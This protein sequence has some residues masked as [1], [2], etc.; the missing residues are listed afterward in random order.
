LENGASIQCKTNENQTCLHLA[1]EKGHTDVVKILLENGANIKIK[2]KDK[3]TCL[4]L[5]TK[6]GHTDVV[7]I[8]AQNKWLI[9][10]KDKREFFPLGL[11]TKLNHIEVVNCLQE[12]GAELEVLNSYLGNTALHIASENGHLE[13]AESLI[14]NGANIN[15]K[16]KAG[17]SQLFFLYFCIYL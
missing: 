1:S 6:H 15:S 9:S 5:A 11:A 13:I 16:S 2:T 17:Y 10:E 12:L 7:K 4:H 3:E 8:L 14:A